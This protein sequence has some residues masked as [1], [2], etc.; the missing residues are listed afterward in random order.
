MR[1]F[2]ILLLSLLCQTLLGQDI[3]TCRGTTIDGETGETM[4]Y[5][6][7][8]ASSGTAVL[9]N[10]DGSFSMKVLASDTISLHCIGFQTQRIVAR[11]L[12]GRIVLKPNP[13]LMKEVTVLGV[14]TILDRV[15]KQLKRDVK[16]GKESRRQFFCRILEEL[17]GKEDLIE[18][19]IDCRNAVRLQ[20][21]VLLGGRRMQIN[22]A[23]T[24][25][26]SHNDMNMH[27]ILQIGP[28]MEYGNWWQHAITIPFN[29]KNY[30]KYYNW[31]YIMQQDE[32]GRTLYRVTLYKMPR[33][34][35]R[36]IVTGRIYVDAKDY[37]L[38][39]FE[40]HVPDVQIMTSDEEEGSALSTVDIDLSINYSFDR[41][42]IEVED[43][44]YDMKGEKANGRG[45]LF[46][47]DKPVRPTPDRKKKRGIRENMIVSVDEAGF[48]SL[49]WARSGVVAR[50]EQEERIAFGQ[51]LQAESA[52]KRLP[53]FD[54][55]QIASP[56]HRLLLKQLDYFGKNRP[57]EKVYIHMDNQSY[58]LGDTIWFAAYTRNT[59]KDVP[60]RISNVLYVELLN[61]DGFVMERQ[62]VE[63]EKGRGHGAF[64]LD[65]QVQYAGFYELRAYTRWQLNWGRYQHPHPA[66]T[67]EWFL[68]PEL[69]AR[70]FRDYDKLYSRVFPV[71]DKP[72]DSTLQ[73]RGMTPR[74]LRRYFKNEPD[75]H[76]RELSFYPE[77]GRL[78]RGLPCRV[79]YEA[80]WND[81]EW[82]EGHLLVD[83]DSIPT[84][85]RGRGM[86][87]ITPTDKAATLT[88][89]DK[90]GHVVK[91][92]LPEAEEQGATLSVT[93]QDTLWQIRIATAGLPADSLALT[94]MHE[95]VI[96]YFKTL[97]D[98][99]KSMPQ[100]ADG[101][102][103]SAS[104][105]LPADALRSSGVHQVTLFDTDGRVWCD[106]LFFAALPGSMTPSLSIT[107]QKET[108]EPLELVRLD[109]ATTTPIRNNQSNY[110]SL[111]IREQTD[112]DCSFDNAS[113]LAEMLLSS[114]V[115]GF[116]PDPGWFFEKDDAV[117][118][119][120]LDL[121][122]M[123]QG[124]RRFDWHQ[125]S[126]P[127]AF[128]I[129][130][131]PE[132]QQ[133]LK[134]TVYRGNWITS[135]LR[136]VADFVKGGGRLYLAH[137]DVEPSIKYLP[138]YWSPVSML[139]YL[140]EDEPVHSERDKM[141]KDFSEKQKGNVVIHASLANMAGQRQLFLN[142]QVATNGSFSWELPRIN[143]S[144]M[145]YLGAQV[146]NAKNKTPETFTWRAKLDPEDV[147][148]KQARRLYDES[149]DQKVCIDFPYPR[150]V[151]PYDFYQNHLAMSV[152]G[153]SGFSPNN[154]HV[155]REVPV[156]AKYNGLKAHDDAY[157]AF[158]LDDL[159]AQN[160]VADAGMYFA[161][162]N[163]LANSLFGTFGLE[164]PFSFSDGERIHARV[165]FRFGITMD[166]RPSAGLADLP[167]D[168]VYA[169]QNLRSY[170]QSYPMS[171]GQMKS[172]A[173]Y[174]VIDKWVVYTDF[175]PR[176]AGS[177]RYGGSNVP[178]TSIVPYTYPDDHRHLVTTGRYVQLPG[179]SMCGDFYHPDYG[180][181]PLPADQHDYRRTLYWNPSLLLGGQGKATV[182]FYNNSRRTRLIID[183][184]GQATNGTLLWSK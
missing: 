152:P 22:N 116:V 75:N 42:F 144:C 26:A 16:A 93:Q 24:E 92:R 183:A 106:R 163:K 98:I 1:P 90:E 180:K 71:Y 27:H 141:Q 49:M 105:L 138:D 10:L 107:G 17:N 181:H 34:V 149:F 14:E 87:T 170:S 39:R 176:L 81:G 31:S 140:E 132:K 153:L 65:H 72:Q 119:E 165:N 64:I 29:E 13:K 21:M 74:P 101:D 135:D 137:T 131:M 104:L 145:L 97:P 154:V 15:D 91:A 133:I 69:E 164:Y 103:A 134:G 182:S 95:G 100:Q 82:L 150:F 44:H 117:H 86:F 23:E 110:I 61:Q 25:K 36:R 171:P 123:T 33:T 142:P 46:G 28:T 136:F 127:S 3:I 111:A 175:N 76:E 77:G 99:L 166:R 129:Y 85:S 43:L 48:D 88:F 45:V 47:L 63:M 151:K 157:P 19:F 158:I 161:F 5:V 51:S 67:K 57:Q 80:T 169:P 155:M 60:S 102:K 83:G 113:I 173:G 59:G 162:D 184:E 89:R 40:G 54:T 177:K 178:E 115:K 148:P 6:R 58:F 38:L 139:P 147:K 41:G 172:F 37:H 120:A 128:H 11:K 78:V 156:G 121:L 79:A 2:V 9:S 62:L 96:E 109:I 35:G 66:V 146:E 8:Q 108:Y 114:E 70:Y 112:E 118:R 125:M 20:D 12:S 68:S 32:E 18:S 84:V 56:S 143:Q 160:I 168:S 55:L 174:G 159:E 73:E 179:F 122:M 50:T 4:P 94:V 53:A 130:E 7:L 126:Q 30:R 52:G 124:W 167:E